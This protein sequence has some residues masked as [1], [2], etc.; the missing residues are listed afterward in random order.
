MSAAVI[1]IFP[2]PHD[3]HLIDNLINATNKKKLPALSS[4]VL[5]SII[6]PLRITIKYSDYNGIKSCVCH[7]EGAYVQWQMPSDLGSVPDSQNTCLGQS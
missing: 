3:K 2:L 4:R 7:C 1:N 5:S 6:L